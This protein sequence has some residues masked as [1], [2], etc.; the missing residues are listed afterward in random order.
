MKRWAIASILTA[1][2]SA[3]VSAEDPAPA[4]PAAPPAEAAP[5]APAAPATPA[6]SSM[7]Y[8]GQP[9]TDAWLAETFATYG[10]NLYKRSDGGGI[11]NI[12]EANYD[13]EGKV[14][15]PPK[16]FEADVS[17]AVPVDLKG[18]ICKF[19]GLRVASKAGSTYTVSRDRNRLNNFIFASR[20]TWVEG[21]AVKHSLF[22]CIDNA[23]V[24]QVMR[25]RQLAYTEVPPMFAEVKPATKEDFLRYIK[26]GNKL[27]GSYKVI[28]EAEATKLHYGEFKVSEKTS[29]PKYFKPVYV[30]PPKAQ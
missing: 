19:E 24:E 30:M 12:V 29:P 26:N 23:H 2:V 22:V 16:F 21:E 9:V 25:N 7:T 6:A 28:S 4:P 5:E 11:L 18:K 14:I 27:A 3:S 20:E 13:E 15:T 8:M 1:L 10:K 17:K